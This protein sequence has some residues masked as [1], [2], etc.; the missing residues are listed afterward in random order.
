MRLLALMY[1]RAQA[2]RHGN[3]PAML[4]AHFAHVARHHACV[5]PGEALDPR[6]LNV[7][8][9]FDDG[10]FDFYAVVFPLLKKHGLRAV[11]AVPPVVVHEQAERPASARLRASG[12]IDDRQ[13]GH[14]GF[15][16]WTE[17]HELAQS[18]HV[19]IA[20]HG[21][22]HQR[23]DRDGVDFH[24]EVVI[25]QA[26]LAARVGCKVD[27]FV[28]PYG[29]FNRAALRIVQLHYRYVFRIGGADNADWSRH[30]LYRIDADGMT[31]PHALF[32]PARLARYRLRRLWNRV[33]GR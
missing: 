19:A 29:R 10:Y 1:H 12:G 32:S 23:L 26:L 9:T 2:E 25:P 6:R 30:V 20:A 27:T 11:L 5:L 8:L 17:L 22:T 28:F 16:T 31:S 21:F 24:T 7:C 13:P 15:C 14:G 33:R 4:E 3:S 18:G